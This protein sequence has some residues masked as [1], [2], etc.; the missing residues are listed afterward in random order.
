LNRVCGLILFTILSFQLLA[1][2]ATLEARAKW[3][4]AQ[5]IELKLPPGFYVSDSTRFYLIDTAV[6]FRSDEGLI[7]P[8][9]G[10]RNGKAVLSTSD[11]VPSQIDEL[12][13]GPLR[14]VV[15]ANNKN[16]LDSTAI[17]YAGLLDQLYATDEDLGSRCSSSSCQLKLW[18][19]TAENVRLLLYRN[20]DTPTEQAEILSMDRSSLGV[21][22]ISLPPRYKNAFYHF[23]VRVYQPLLGKVESALITD[24]YS[25]SLSLDSKKSQLVD[26]E[27]SELRP[28]G[29]NNLRKPRFQS[30]KDVIIYEL[31]I[32]DFSSIDSQLD[33]EMRGSYLAFTESQSRGRRHLQD[34]ARAGLTY[35]HLLPFND[36]GTVNEDRSK[37][38]NYLGSSSQLQ[39]PQTIIGG[40]RAED[41]F[42]WGYDPVHYFVPEGSYSS[43]PDGFTRI[44]EVRSMIQSLNQDGLR[45]IQDVV[46]NHTFESGDARLS[47]FDKIVP[48]YYYR[49]DDNGKVRNSSCCSDTA[50][51]NK[52]MEKLMVDAVVHWARTY[53]IDGFRFD[54]MNFHSRS[55]MAKVRS[56]VRN[57]TLSKDG[58]DGTEILL[59]GEG[60]SFGSF[61]EQQPRE[62]M[63]IEN[64]YDTQYAFFND[65]LRD[66]VRGGTT[67]SNEK[68]DQGFATGLFFDFNYEPANRNT[69]T[70]LDEQKERLLHYGD[71]IKVGLAGN[72]RD[73]YF[74]E[75]K[76]STIRAG[77]LTFRN[78]GV[79]FASQAL[80]TINYVSAHDGYGLWDAVQAKAP[81]YSYGRYPGTATIEER[82]R[83]HHLALSI[84][85]LGQGIPFVESGTELLRSKNGDQDSYDSGD[86]FNRI[87][88]TGRT[89]F[90]GAGLP[91]SW[92]NY[93]DWSFWKPRLEEQA[94]HVTPQL[95]EQ[96]R[97][98][99]K[100]LLRLR[101]SSDLFK[102]NT[103]SEITQHLHFIDNDQQVEP[104]LIAM[105]LA[106]NEEELL[107]F[108]NAS[109][110]ARNFQHN[111]LRNSWQLHPLFDEQ[112]DPVLSQ[113]VLSPLAG[114][115]QLP[116]RSTVVLQLRKEK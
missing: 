21:W 68:S 94:L 28:S 83:M 103:A 52:M 88:W 108:F 11:I 34:L 109:R 16:V 64:S 53:K 63:T 38:Q 107:I 91:P 84:P 30:F 35:I 73:F 77:D 15:S 106:D 78:T 32:R 23:E 6:V 43:D 74:R 44:R 40:Q 37:W 5:E 26:L 12:I 24:P 45:V 96:T 46:F 67:N 56:A 13:R 62:A 85:L 25:F 112:I 99:F 79:A 36:F 18:A 7:L 75:H 114:S 51:E 72:L 54:L 81:F 4:N 48:L 58:V 111:A 115:I 100:A 70:N 10:M 57:L 50:S 49:L 105:L 20:S 92:K 29:W 89:N 41:P 102:L 3:V 104:G 39:E 69:P 47:V 95:I 61:Y 31:H 80:E 17:Q 76:G 116:G 27:S 55:T 98:Y 82:Q 66:A 65:R 86:F 97:E 22:S 33:A 1:T 93:N 71:V 59:Y 42:N 113:V 2:A 60:W 14:V 8:Y 101:Q 87:D 90:W 110:A 19:P 9:Q